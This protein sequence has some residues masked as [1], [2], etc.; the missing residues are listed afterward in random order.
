MVVN[1]TG[2]P[3]V[4]CLLVAYLDGTKFG[5]VGVKFLAYLGMPPVAKFGTPLVGFS[6]VMNSVCFMLSITYILNYYS[7]VLK[8]NLY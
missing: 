4:C 8:Y 5:T 3:Q 2:V 1:Q 7:L 6:L